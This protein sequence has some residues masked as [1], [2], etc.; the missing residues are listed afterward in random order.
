MFANIDKNKEALPMI[1]KAL[2]ID[3]N[4]TAALDTKGFILYNL[5]RYQEAITYYDRALAIDPNYADA[6][7]HKALAIEKVGEKE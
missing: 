4:N 2:S 6:R 3:P 7:E 5:E 1:E